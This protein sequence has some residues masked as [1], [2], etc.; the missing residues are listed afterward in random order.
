MR[1]HSSIIVAGLVTIFFAWPMITK[2]ATITVTTTADDLSNNGNCTLREAIQAANTNLAVDACVAGSASGTDTITLGAT[3]YTTTLAGADED[4]NLTGDFDIRSSIQINGAGMTTTIIDG[5]SLDR[6]F[7][8]YSGAYLDLRYLTVQNGKVTD[9]LGGGIYNAGD[10][11]FQDVVLASNTVVGNSP[12]IVAGGGMYSVGT[13]AMNYSVVKNNSV[14]CGSA[15][16]DMASGGGVE[17]YIGRSAILGSTFENNVAQ[18]SGSGLAF[19]GGISN[20]ATLEIDISTIS[21]NQV[22]SGDS[23]G[24]TNTAAGVLT[25]NG[26]TVAKNTASNG[27]GGIVNDPGATTNMTNTL[28]AGNTD[29]SSS[30][31]DCSG[32]LTSQGYNLIQSVTGCTVSGVTTGNIT[33]QPALISSLADNGYKTRTHA[34][35]PH[36]PAIDAGNPLTCFS[37][38]ERGQGRDSIN[39]LAICDI[40]AYEV[41]TAPIITEVTSIPTQN[42][43]A[44][45]LYA[46]STN[47]STSSIIVGGDCLNQTLHSAAIGTNTTLFTVTEGTHSNCTLKIKDHLGVSSNILSLATFTV[48]LT[49]PRIALKGQPVINLKLGQAFVDP[50]VLVS[51]NLDAGIASRLVTTYDSGTPMPF[52]VNTA[53][54][55]LLFYYVTDAAGNRAVSGVYRTV[56]VQPAVSTITLSKQSI[57]IKNTRGKNVTITPFDKSYK[58]QI[59]ARKIKFAQSVDVVYAFF[60]LGST[61]QWQFKAYNAD[62]KQITIKW[63]KGKMVNQLTIPAAQTS[64]G[65]NADLAIDPI[66]NQVLIAVTP[67]RGLNIPYVYTLS[68]NSVTQITV[69]GATTGIQGDSI[70][71]L[72]VTDGGQLNIVTGVANKKNQQLR[73]WKSNSSGTKFTL[74]AKYNTKRIS[75]KGRTISLVPPVVSK[76]ALTPTSSNTQTISWTL[77][78]N[79]DGVINWGTTKAYGNLKSDQSFVKK[80]GMTFTTVAGQTYHYSIRSCVKGQVPAV[81]CTSTPDMTFKAY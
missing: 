61:K 54:S 55:Y 16:G 50:G 77:D 19:G 63:A 78:K 28:L 5:N 62:G 68:K 25:L 72:L 45:V 71:K 48:D 4:N 41:N 31:P 76:L 12:C 29:S 17:N 33:G 58:G 13:F 43:Q 79:A 51:D 18:S 60:M 75:L 52:P 38:D 40:G 73:V 20:Y 39:N 11:Y 1:L 21:G 14:T 59:F 74:D 35:D 26:V 37:T 8:V 69:A 81:G 30:A 70:S 2:A 66:T 57:V 80:H 9:D 46:F 3:T 7:D 47:K 44:T 6:V 36:S 65:V 32:T 27:A 10:M 42:H 15:G 53:G 34:L 67:K 22:I 56:N 24:I 49:A 23:G 64:A